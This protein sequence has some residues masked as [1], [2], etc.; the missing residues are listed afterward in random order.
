MSV[1]WIETQYRYMSMLVKQNVYIK[2]FENSR[3]SISP[4]KVA[5]TIIRLERS[6]LARWPSGSRH[7][8]GMMAIAGS[9]PRRAI[10]FTTFFINY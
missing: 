4:A 9:I 5:K 1:A 8:P 7:R 3:V 2:K 10:F 6:W